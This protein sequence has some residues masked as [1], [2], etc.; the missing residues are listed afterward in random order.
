ME[1]HVREGR[2]AN[3]QRSAVQ[4]SLM[5]ADPGAPAGARRRG[6]LLILAATLAL[7][8]GSLLLANTLAYDPFSWLIWGREV[9]HLDLHTDAGSAWKPLPA[10][11][12]T[13]LAPTGDAAPVLWMLL[14]RTGTVL[15]LVFAY[16]L[17]ARLAGPLAG[18]LAAVWIVLMSRPG[19]LFG[20]T[21]FFGG[22]WSEGPLVALC[23]LAVERHLD[24]RREHCLLLLLAA[25]LIRPEAWPFLAGYAVYLWRA[26]PARRRLAALSLLAVPVLWI[27]PDFL[28][29]GNLLG[30][31]DRARAAVPSGLAHARYPALKVLGFVADL[32]SPLVAVGALL[33]LGLA[34][35]RRE[36]VTLALGAAAAGWVAIVAVMA[37]LGYPGVA[38]Y[39]VVGLALA[40]VLAGVGWARVTA[41]APRSPGGAHAAILVAVLAVQLPS[42]VTRTDDVVRE[43]HGLK[44]SDRLDDTLAHALSAAG[45]AQAVR[46]CGVAATN[47][48]YV[49][50]LSWRIGLGAR[51]TYHV[52]PA[53]LVF[54]GPASFGAPYA[55]AVGRR[56]RG[57]RL[58]ARARPWEVLS[59]CPR[60]HGGAGT[61]SPARYRSAKGLEVV[62]ASRREFSSTLDEPSTEPG[63]PLRP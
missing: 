53:S 45:G 12:D 27:G 15:S 36:L 47:P 40:C 23:L 46:R 20:W 34:A 43:V 7:S 54:R 26:E 41:L 57:F 32:L 37:E 42:A 29:S 31:S 6:G 33:A 30:A 52:R 56:D 25:S 1:E 5:T 24:R 44:G 8:A 63:H 38:R 3:E 61:R 48:F 59:R 28:G 55:P 49:P 18:G 60:I 13:V 17:A 62:E 4:S 2:S 51:V 19:L 50:A 9:L 39:L 21:T 10:L 35:R 11:I 14:A 16:R 58:V 22:G